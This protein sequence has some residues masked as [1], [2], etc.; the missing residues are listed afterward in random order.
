MPK[1]WSRLMADKEGGK[2]NMRTN[3]FLVFRNGKLITALTTTMDNYNDAVEC[4][5][6]VKNPKNAEKQVEEWLKPKT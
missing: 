6:Y 4:D 1:L 2:T 5:R 3:T